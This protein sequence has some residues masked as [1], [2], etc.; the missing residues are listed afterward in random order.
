MTPIQEKDIIELIRKEQYDLAIE[1]IVRSYSKMLFAHVVR[2]VKDEAS[3]QDVLQNTMMKAWKG[4]AGF[5]QDAKLGTWLYRIASNEAIN[6]LRKNKRVVYHEI[7]EYQLG[8]ADP[9]L[10]GKQVEALLYAA[11]DTLPDKQRQVFVLRYFDEMKYQEMSV[12]LGTSEGALKA[13]YHHAVRK[14]EDFLKR[15]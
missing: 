13:S 14:I 7:Q 4:L 2:M 9:E 1:S 8:V 12:M 15:D 5:R 10:D 3:A 11:M 6:H